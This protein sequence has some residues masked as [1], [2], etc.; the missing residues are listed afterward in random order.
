MLGKREGE[1]LTDGRWQIFG[2]ESLQQLE[3]VVWGV[4]SC[5]MQ[6]GIGVGKALQWFK[7][8]AMQGMGTMAPQ[9]VV[10]V[11]LPCQVHW[12]ELLQ[13]AKVFSKP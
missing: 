4:R 11:G 5:E 12:Q 7:A 1:D 10:L 2:G 9:L 13:V 3:A 6:M 8:K